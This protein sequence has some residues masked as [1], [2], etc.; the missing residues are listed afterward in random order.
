M[1]ELQKKEALPGMLF[2]PS[3]CATKQN[4][5][6]PCSWYIDIIFIALNFLLQ[7]FHYFTSC[8]WVEVKVKDMR[9]NFFK[10]NI[11]CITTENTYVCIIQAKK[12]IVIFLRTLR[13]IFLTK[14]KGQWH[15]VM[16][17]LK[18]YHKKRHKL[19]NS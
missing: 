13:V 14:D 7:F 17:L 10:I 4:I 2:C 1:T 5:N 8:I 3:I 9:W 15:H 18:L 11:S 16:I 19:I 12:N 6:K